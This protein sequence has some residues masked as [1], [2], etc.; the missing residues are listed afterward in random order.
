MSTKQKKFKSEVEVEGFDISKY[1]LSSESE[2][3]TVVIPETGDEFSVQVKPIPWSRRNKIVSECLN[4]GD[5]SSVDFDGDKYVRECLRQMIVQAPWGVTD[6]KFLVS[7]D[8][9]LGSALEAL[10]PKAFG[11]EGVQTN[12]AKKG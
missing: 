12:L 2:T 3:Y 7:I 9:R 10:V 1:I 8:A 11:D 4:W 5:G 6:E